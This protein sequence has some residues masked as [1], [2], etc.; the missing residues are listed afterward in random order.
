MKNKNLGFFKEITGAIVAG[1]NVV[2]STND[3]KLI[4]DMT[5]QEMEE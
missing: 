1:A 2:Y 3:M 4:Q 5:D